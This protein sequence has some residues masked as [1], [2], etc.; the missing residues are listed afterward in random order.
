MNVSF[1][2][3]GGGRFAPLAL[4][5]I[6]VASLHLPAL[7]AP[8]VGDDFEILDGVGF[9]SLPGALL[10]PDPQGNAF[11]P[12]GRQL[13][14]WFVTHLG[15][16]SPVAAHAANLALFLIALGLPAWVARRLVGP[17]AATIPVALVGLS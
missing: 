2:A 4:L 14:F 11:R 1:R 16:G 7:R 13:H 6:L 10:A 9:R 12:V 8:F 17:Y 3:P 15:G 5:F